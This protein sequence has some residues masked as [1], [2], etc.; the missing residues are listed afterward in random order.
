MHV[1]FGFSYHFDKFDC[2]S[3]YNILE[4]Q[5]KY[6]PFFK[7]SKKE[8][9]THVMKENCHIGLLTLHEP[10]ASSNTALHSYP[11]FPSMLETFSLV[12]RPQKTRI[13]DIYAVIHA[14]ERMTEYLPMEG[15]SNNTNDNEK[16]D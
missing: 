2:C 11:K 12:P 8:K 16:N 13:R 7:S 14:R 5:K 1:D 15:K 9:N 3:E 10:K 6:A 4:I